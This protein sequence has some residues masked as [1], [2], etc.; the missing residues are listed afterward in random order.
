MAEGTITPEMS[1][2]DPPAHWAMSLV[3]DLGP[4]ELSAL[5]DIGVPAPEKRKKAA[6]VIQGIVEKGKK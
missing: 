6:R 2:P 1:T 4:D 3:N 5:R